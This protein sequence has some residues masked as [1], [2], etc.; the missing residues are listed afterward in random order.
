MKPVALILTLAGATAAGLV[1]GQVAVPGKQAAKAGSAASAPVSTAAVASPAAPSYR[2]VSWDDLT[3]KDWDPLK[4][5]R[6]MN[7][8]ALSDS[9]PKAIAMLQR[10]RETWDNAPTNLAMDGQN[11][12]I[13]GYLVPLDETKDGLIQF[14]L[15]PYFGA[16]IHTPPP[17]SNQIIEVRPKQP[18]KGYR[19]MD[20]VWVSGTLRTLRSET[21]MGTSSY[22]MEAM[23][24][25]PYVR[26][27][28]DR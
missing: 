13:A 17:P 5:F 28:V 4:Q 3:P 6:D 22:R 27:S 7:F 25:E 24:V 23:R 1:L 8:G 16:C 19:P 26:N 2:E 21:Y 14:L 15:V 11:V 12:R 18:S 20:T 9:D 10:M